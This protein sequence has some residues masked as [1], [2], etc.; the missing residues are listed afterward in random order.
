MKP[1]S[2]PKAPDDFGKI[3]GACV[4][5][6]RLSPSPGPAAD[7]LPLAANFAAIRNP[8]GAARRAQTCSEIP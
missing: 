5:L 4:C 3:P 6:T 2:A 7:S 8:S 1:H